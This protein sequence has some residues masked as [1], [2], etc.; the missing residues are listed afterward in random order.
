MAVKKTGTSFVCYLLDFG[1]MVTI[2]QT[3]MRPLPSE[4]LTKPPCAFQVYE[5]SGET[6]LRQFYLL[7]FVWLVLGLRMDRLSS[8]MRLRFTRKL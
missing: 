4:F 7:R 8:M 6:I 5:I 1:N 3:N 2:S